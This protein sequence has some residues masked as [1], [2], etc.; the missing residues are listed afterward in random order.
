[1][2]HSSQLKCTHPHVTNPLGPSDADIQELVELHKS[3]ATTSV[4]PKIEAFVQRYPAFVSGWQVLG[5]VRQQLG[6]LT[7]ALEAKQQ[8][9]QLSPSDPFCHNNLANTLTR[10][11]RFGD[12]EIAYRNA[13][14]L[15]PGFSDAYVNLGDC[16][17]RLS[18]HTEAIEVIKQGLTVSPVSVIGWRNLGNAYFG[19]GQ[20]QEA[21]DA[22]ERCISV[23]QRYKHA[24]SNLSACY[25]R[26]GR[27]ED[28][29]RAAL[30]AIDI[31]PN[32]AEAFCNLGNALH[33]LE[34]LEEAERVLR[35]SIALNASSSLASYNLANVLFAT[36]RFVEA[37]HFY[38]RSLALNAQAADAELN[39]GMLNLLTQYGPGGFTGYQRRFAVHANRVLPSVFRNPAPSSV[40]SLVG[41]R[42]AVHWEQGLGDTIQFCRFVPILAQVAAEVHFFPQG[43]LRR[44]IGSLSGA[45]VTST[46]DFVDTGFDSYLSTMDLPGVF[47]GSEYRFGVTPPY[48]SADPTRIERFAA[49]SG[50]LNFRIGICWQGSKAKIDKGRS[51][52]LRYFKALADIPGVRLISLH[53][54]SGVGQLNDP[55]LGFR[56]ETLGDEFDSDKHAFLDT[57]AVMMYCDL[58]I[59]SDTAIAHLAGALGRPTWVL[60]RLVPDWRWYVGSETSPWYPT[61]RL[62]RQKTLDD[63]VSVFADV[64]SALIEFTANRAPVPR[65]A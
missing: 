58:I 21:I 10:L 61:M 17:N 20:Y 16:L 42:I 25:G 36:A 18:R 9:L 34:E 65:L 31:D 2:I 52:P 45:H 49:V 53:K 50:S 19:L 55:S 4:L 57:A 11:D 15:D 24:Y 43:S 41:K 33:E 3:A 22:Y 60:L 29:K 30:R 13:I 12:A 8:A 62:F 1:M 35:R 48:L 51:F 44:L 14:A 54:G 64:H 40:A 32:Y 23:D 63:W 5:S 39:L 46:G 47:F 27:Y 59:T 26:L 56:V 38:E 28:A 6:D 37:R 7:G